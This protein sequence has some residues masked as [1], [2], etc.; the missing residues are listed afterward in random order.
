LEDSPGNYSQLILAGG[1]YW[2]VHPR[3]N[4]RCYPRAFC[5]YCADYIALYGKRDAGG[6]FSSQHSGSASGNRPG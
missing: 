2:G 1:M 5:H 3:P 4:A 6:F